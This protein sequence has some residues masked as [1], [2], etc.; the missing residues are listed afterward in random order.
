MQ[1]K[2]HPGIIEL[3][4]GGTSTRIIQFLRDVSQNNSATN[5]KLSSILPRLDVLGLVQVY[6]RPMMTKRMND[7]QRLLVE[8]LDSRK[9]RPLS[10]LRLTKDCV[11]DM[12]TILASVPDRKLIG[13][14]ACLKKRMLDF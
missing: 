13:D 7:F 3:D 12:N 5:T 6:G 1:V 9:D 14:E 10:Q 4:V 8:F 11:R 2:R